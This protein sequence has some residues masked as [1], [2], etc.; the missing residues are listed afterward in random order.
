MPT[1]A[2]HIRFICV[3][4]GIT[5][6]LV[7]GFYSGLSGRVRT[8]SLF[9]LCVVLLLSSR[10]TATALVWLSNFLKYVFGIPLFIPGNIKI[11]VS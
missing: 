11:N 7:L 4:L 6:I 9:S 8:V 10:F 3:H 2:T 5:L 1:G